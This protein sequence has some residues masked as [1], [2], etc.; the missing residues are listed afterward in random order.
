MLSIVSAARR[1]GIEV[2]VVAISGVWNWLSDGKPIPDMLD[3][4][5]DGGELYI[6]FDSHVFSNPDVG[7]AACRLGEHLMGRGGA[8]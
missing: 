4:P 8:V 6:C 7:D 2:L 3:I 1:A 5:V